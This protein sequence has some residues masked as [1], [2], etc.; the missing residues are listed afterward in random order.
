[1]KGFLTCHL[2]VVALRHDVG[3]ALGVVCPF[4]GA[5]PSMRHYVQQLRMAPLLRVCFHTWLL[6]SLQ[7]FCPRWRVSAVTGHET[8]I[9][10][11]HDLFGIRLGSDPFHVPVPYPCATVGLT[12]EV[13]PRDVALLLARRITRTALH[14]V[15]YIL[16]EV[17]ALYRH[18][19]F[20]TLAVV[21]R[22]SV[23]VRFL[24]VRPSLFPHV[25]LVF[26]FAN[27]GGARLA[28]L[29][30]LRGLAH[31][32]V[33]FCACAVYSCRSPRS[34]HS[35]VASPHAVLVGGPQQPTSCSQRCRYTTMG[36]PVGY[37][38]PPHH[39]IRRG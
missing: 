2:M 18:H 28:A 13:T 34:S 4:C 9:L 21:P 14:V 16:N 29:C 7:P 12:G 30:P 17:V 19:S 23:R 39:G 3:A 1:M 25:H 5:P 22:P 24:L 27:H 32:R 10:H 36:Q 35:P 8:C 20:R 26:E 37:P 33:F 31:Y 6:L 15:S 11:G 38:P